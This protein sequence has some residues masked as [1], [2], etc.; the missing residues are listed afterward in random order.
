[1]SLNSYLVTNEI[2]PLPGSGWTSKNAANAQDSIAKYKEKLNIPRGQ[3]GYIDPTVFNLKDDFNKDDLTNIEPK[4][5][6]VVEKPECVKYNYLIPEKY[7]KDGA[8][9]A[10]IENQITDNNMVG[11]DGSEISD[12][13]KYFKTLE[14]E[15]LLAHTYIKQLKYKITL[16]RQE[17][18]HGK[19][20]TEGGRRS[21]THKRGSKRR[22]RSKKFP[23]K[24]FSLRKREK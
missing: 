10:K 3:K 23:R 17:S 5:S 12:I 19:Y 15:I 2:R 1:M 16:L 21:L 24:C 14:N 22:L 13:R 8:K 9:N 6:C 11:L 7:L 20:P 4:R 18:L